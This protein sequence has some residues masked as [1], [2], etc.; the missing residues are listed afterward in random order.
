M[1]KN[2]NSNKDISAIHLRTQALILIE[3]PWGRDKDPRVPLGHASLLTKLKSENN[4]NIYSVVSEVNSTD[5]NIKSIFHKIINIINDNQAIQIDIA[6]GVYVWSEDIIQKLLPKIRNKGF[7]GRII[8]GGPQISYS[9]PGLEEF[10]PDADVFIR[11]YGENAL[12]SLLKNNNKK[13]IPGVHY[14]AEQDIVQQAT[15]NLELLPSP[16]LNDII[17]IKE[18]TFIRWETQR[19]CPFRCSFCQHKE[20][21]ARLKSRQFSACRIRDE[22]DLFCSNNVLDIAVLDPIFNASPMAILILKRFIEKKYRGRLSLQCRAEMITDEFIELASELDVCLEF[23]LQTIHDNEGTAIE[24]RNNIPKVDKVLNKINHTN[25]E[26]EVSLIFGLPEQTLES[27]Y[28]T[29][30]W[31]LKRSVPVIKAFPLMLLRG[32]GIDKERKKWN[33]SES[34]GSM[35]VVLSSNTFNYNEWCKMAQI[36]MAL[37][38]TEGNHPSNLDEL[39]KIAK[40]Q[41]I[42]STRFAPNLTIDEFHQEVA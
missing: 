34:G 30:S 26:Y 22:I 6:M 29:I 33:L 31:C 10:Y 42:D 41:E 2:S 27:F 19:G 13:R 39:I 23:G 8:L 32:T 18:Q 36:S 40:K 37:S 28:E 16:W 35:P 14:A 1:N 21:G 12:C 5:F 24:R 3:F 9:G 15:A 20:A 4:I 7:I 11:G 17:E 38:S 25:I